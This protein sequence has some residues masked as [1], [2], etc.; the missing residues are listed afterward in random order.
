MA[1]RHSHASCPFTS[2]LKWIQIRLCLM[3]NQCTS[4]SESGYHPRWMGLGRWKSRARWS[5]E[6][7]DNAL[8]AKSQMQLTQNTWNDL[9]LRRQAP[10]HPCF[11]RSSLL[12]SSNFLHFLPRTGLALVRQLPKTSGPST[13]LISHIHRPLCTHSELQGPLK[14]CLRKF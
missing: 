14:Y 8:L 6:T 5:Q 3:A 11:T 2:S 12:F 1:H 4:A 9:S 13:P 10:A 7:V